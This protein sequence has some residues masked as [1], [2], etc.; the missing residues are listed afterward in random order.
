M[1]KGFRRIVFM[2]MGLTAITVISVGVYLWYN[3]NTRSNLVLVIPA[4]SKRVLHV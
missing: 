1:D 2:L 4:S 3:F